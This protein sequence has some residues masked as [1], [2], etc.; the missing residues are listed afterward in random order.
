MNNLLAR[1][2]TSATL[3]TNIT[4]HLLPI[5]VAAV[6]VIFLLSAVIAYMVAKWQPKS[7]TETKKSAKAAAKKKTT[8]K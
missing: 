1:A 5:V 3:G 6:I 8:K 2:D 7:F 4:D